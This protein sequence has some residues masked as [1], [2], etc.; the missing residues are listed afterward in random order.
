MLSSFAKQSHSCS[1]LLAD[2]QLNNQMCYTKHVASEMLGLETV[3][4]PHNTGQ[5]INIPLMEYLIL[6]NLVLSAPDRIN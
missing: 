5:K 1:T 4:S 6:S 2:S 3:D